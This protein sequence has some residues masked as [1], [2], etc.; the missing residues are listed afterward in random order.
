[1]VTTEEYE[2]YVL[3]VDFRLSSAP[4]QG[5]SGVILR[6]GEWK[7]VETTTLETAIYPSAARPG[8][9]CTG[10]F[11]HD[12]RNPDKAV[13]RPQGE[14]NTFV[15]TVRGPLIDIE[16]NGEKVNRLDLNEWGT[17][18]KRPDGSAHKMTRIAP[19]DLPGRSAIGF[20]EDHGDP[21]W[22]KNLKLRPLP[23]P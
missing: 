12:L 19:K 10:A 17:P 23:G 8:M 18:G 11:R 22:F 16:L 15:F 21:V 6:V 13:A 9:F 3:K 5:H 4:K 7:N 2:N 1:L 14:W 20:R